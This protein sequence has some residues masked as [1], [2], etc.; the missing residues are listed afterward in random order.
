LKEK[1]YY[2]LT[3][4]Y[5][6]LDVLDE[7]RVTKRK[8]I[9]I[10]RE[11]F[12]VFGFKCIYNFCLTQ[13]GWV[14]SHEDCCPYCVHC[15]VNNDGSREDRVNFNKNHDLGEKYNIAVTRKDRAERSKRI[16]KNKKNDPRRTR[17]RRM[18][19]RLAKLKG[20]DYIE[21][22]SKELQKG[23]KDIKKANISILGRGKQNLWNDIFRYSSNPNEFTYIKGL[24]PIYFFPVISEGEDVYDYL[25]EEIEHQNKRYGLKINKPERDILKRT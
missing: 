9:K 12:D 18:S 10:D 6:Y 23:L 15:I 16:R 20:S 25:I 14:A 7:H 24:K 5:E 11:P 19:R 22:S 21:M 17:Q 4:V 2:T 1:R 3:E 13:K 8:E